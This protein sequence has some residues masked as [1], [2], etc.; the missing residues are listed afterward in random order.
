MA[1]SDSNLSPDDNQLNKAM[2]A[3]SLGRQVVESLG[4]RI[5]II[6]DG[7]DTVT[8]IF[9]PQGEL[10]DKFDSAGDSLDER[11]EWEVEEGETIPNYSLDLNVA[12]KLEVNGYYLHIYQ[13]VDCWFAHYA[14]TPENY[15]TNSAT[16]H[17]AETPAVAICKAFL[18]LAE[19]RNI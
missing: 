5:N 6:V 13:G 8:E 17:S 12:I 15:L 3:K 2:G 1:T 18:A 7:W 4:W 9:N 11:W 14:P 16:V 10:V 19:Y